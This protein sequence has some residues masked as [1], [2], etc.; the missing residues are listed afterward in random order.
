MDGLINQFLLPSLFCKF[1]E[2]RCCERGLASAGGDMVVPLQ[3]QEMSDLIVQNYA[4]ASMANMLKEVVRLAG[5][6]WST[7]RLDF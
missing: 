4:Q 5:F 6:V 1:P 2:S 3:Q 7:G